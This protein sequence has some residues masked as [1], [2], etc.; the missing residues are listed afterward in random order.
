M[1]TAIRTFDYRG[2]DVAGKE[3]KGSHRGTERRR[4]THAAAQHER[5]ADDDL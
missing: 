1:S 5:P 4:G 2:R 3:V